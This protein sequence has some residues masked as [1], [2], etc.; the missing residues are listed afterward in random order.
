[1]LKR[2]CDDVIIIVTNH[3]RRYFLFLSDALFV[4]IWS[5]AL[6]HNILAYNLV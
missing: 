3:R 5:D 1:M 6:R 2:Q 4:T